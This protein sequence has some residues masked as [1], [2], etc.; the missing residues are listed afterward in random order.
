M[1][2]VCLYHSCINM[3][4]RLL[5]IP[6]LPIP[7]R[8]IDNE[9]TQ[10]FA[11]IDNRENLT[12]IVGHIFVTMHPEFY[13]EQYLSNRNFSF[14][15]ENSRIIL[16]CYNPFVFVDK[17]NIAKNIVSF[18]KWFIP[19]KALSV[20]LKAIYKWLYSLESSER[21][22]QKCQKI[23]QSF[24]ES[25]GIR[26]QSSSLNHFSRKLILDDPFLFSFLSLEQKEALQQ[27]RDESLTREVIIDDL[28]QRWARVKE[29][30]FI[31]IQEKIGEFPSQSSFFRK[32]K[33]TVVN[34]VDTLCDL[35]CKIDQCTQTPD[36][37]NLPSHAALEDRVC[38]TPQQ[39]WKII[40][41]R[42]NTMLMETMLQ[43]LM[44]TALENI[45]K[46]LNS[47]AQI[48]RDTLGEEQN[49]ETMI[50][51]EKKYLRLLCNYFLFSQIALEKNEVSWL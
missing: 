32:Y 8:V 38:I 17:E 10:R 16:E 49:L 42:V 5:P 47:I 26:L 20:R 50:V 4:Q 14:N 13:K 7:S 6:S 24:F 43:S 21:F 48:E 9:A 12:K 19:E 3:L 51:Q 40:Q 35:R 25:F 31:K 27:E 22:Y 11:V 36:C 33:E 2:H 29:S 34:R 37:I 1:S 18:L 15:T 39:E 30:V 28:A 41:H 46:Y 44:E 23:Y 45:P